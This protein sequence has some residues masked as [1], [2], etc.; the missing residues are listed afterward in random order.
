[1]SECPSAVGDRTEPAYQSRYLPSGEGT[2]VYSILEAVAE[3]TGSSPSQLDE[4]LYESVDPDALEQLFE[5]FDE[6]AD[7]Y[8]SFDFCG[9]RVITHSDGDIDVYD[10][11][12]PATIGT[13]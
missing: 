4:P 12:K 13:I 11:T 2:I 1:M 5:S 6:S 10:E 9:V 8:V 3:V 7:G